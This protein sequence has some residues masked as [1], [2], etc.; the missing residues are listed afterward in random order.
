MKYAKEACSECKR[1]KIKV[2]PLSVRK[3]K[4]CSNSLSV[5]SV[6]AR[7]H[8]AANKPPERIH[9][10]IAEP[11]VEDLGLGNMPISDHPADILNALGTFPFTSAQQHELGLDTPLTRL[12]SVWSRLHAEP[13]LGL[14]LKCGFDELEF[15]YP[16]IDRTDFYNRLSKILPRSNVIYEGG[17]CEIPQAEY[18][19]LAA[20]VCRLLS[21]AVFLGAGADSHEQGDGHYLK[22]SWSWHLE[23]QKL[24]SDS[25]AYDCPSFDIIRAYLLEVSYMTMVQRRRDASK[26]IAIAVD[27]A[28]CMGLNNEEAW[29]TNTTREKEHLRLLWWTVFHLDRRVGLMVHRPYLIRD[30]D[31]AVAEMTAQSRDVYC[32]FSPSAGNFTEKD[33]ASPL[34]EDWFDYFLF[35]VKWSKIATQAWDKF[36]TLR[37]SKSFDSDNLEVIDALLLKLKHDLPS[38]LTWDAKRLPLYIASGECDRAFRLQLIIFERINMLR[39]IVHSRCS[40]YA[41]AASTNCEHSTSVHTLGITENMATTVIDS[42]VDYLTAR[43]GARPWTTYCSMLLAEATTLVTPVVKRQ[44][45]ATHTTYEVIASIERA[46]ECLQALVAFKFH[47]V[48]LACQ[49]LSFILDGVNPGQAMNTMGVTLGHGTLYDDYETIDMFGFAWEDCPGDLE[50][51]IF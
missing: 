9:A 38:S 48:D 1:R 41:G 25:S 47:A 46:K 4:A 31:F 50:D 40:Q 27:L 51:I 44:H 6:A 28:F 17:T 43:N 12:G 23:C 42:I 45:E 37:S 35:S 30:A 19:A 5:D 8:V 29:S 2:W 10:E 32:D 26:A 21:I 34:T 16:C 3:R 20:M 22:A 15:F 33:L 7:N 11:S 39:L 49:R 13:K 36:F 18:R 14:L 24:L